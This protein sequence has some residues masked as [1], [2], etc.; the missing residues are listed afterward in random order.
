MRSRVQPSDR[1]APIRRSP[2]PRRRFAPVRCRGSAG[3]D[4]AGG[5]AAFFAAGGDGAAARAAG[6]AG[7]GR[8]FF[9][10]D[11][12]RGDFFFGRDFFR[13]DFFF[14][15]AAGDVTAR[16][17]GFRGARRFGTVLESIG[18]RRFLEVRKRSGHVFLRRRQA[19]FVSARGGQLG[20]ARRLG[21]FVGGVGELFVAFG[22]VG[23]TERLEALDHA[24]VEVGDLRGLLR[25]FG[26]ADVEAADG[27]VD[28]GADS[29]AL[30][31]Q[32]RFGQGRLGFGGLRRR[33]RGLLAAVAAAAG[34][35][36]AQGEDHADEGRGLGKSRRHGNGDRSRAKGTQSRDLALRPRDS[37]PDYL[38]QSEACCHY[39]RA[40]GVSRRIL[41]A[42]PRLLRRRARRGRCRGRRAGAR[43]RRRLPRRRAGAA[44]RRGPLSG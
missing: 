16:Q 40:H 41:R 1:G 32:V 6:A 11:F 7:F 9:W 10:S 18:G 23:R 37:N 27:G 28:L 26:F 31:D 25:G 42:Q 8:G 14:F 4:A 38:V 43:R 36:Q 30:R 21:Q 35:D 20:I 34:H 33:G 24:A 29:V 2:M 44:L 12:F 13:G 39:T 22:F 17:S 3:A 19:F 15:F 5:P